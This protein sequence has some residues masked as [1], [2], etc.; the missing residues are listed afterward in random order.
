MES[1]PQTPN[2]INPFM[3]MM[4]KMEYVWYDGADICSQT[5]YEN[6]V[7]HMNEGM[8]QEVVLSKCPL[9]SYTDANGID[10]GIKPIKV[11]QNPLE[12]SEMPSFIVLCE[13]FHLLSETYEPLGENNR[14]TLFENTESDLEIGFGIEFS[15][16]DRSTNKTLN[17]NSKFAADFGKTYSVGASYTTGRSI[18]D[19]FIAACH[20]IR[21]PV[22]ESHSSNKS[23][24][25]WFVGFG[26]RSPID[27]TDDL[28]VAK[29]MLMKMTEELNIVV[30]FYSPLRLS[31]STKAMREE[32]GVTEDIV[33][34]FDDRQPYNN[35]EIPPF[36]RRNGYKGHLV[37]TRFTTADNPYEVVMNIAN[38]LYGN[39]ESEQMPIEQQA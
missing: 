9:W 39:G 25:S 2:Q 1:E 8:S 38:V 18:V 33:D 36:V 29:Y 37:E 12:T 17:S 15:L 10:I 7:L 26:M 35:L 11:Y 4:V 22:T 23:T 27:A 16:I 13:R 32:N 30:D 31:F 5:R 24:S 19:T 6:W 3:D 20:M 21:L 34:I 28:I 14:T